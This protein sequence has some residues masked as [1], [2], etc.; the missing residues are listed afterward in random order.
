[1]N[2]PHTELTREYYF[3]KFNRMM[4]E[5]NYIAQEGEQIVQCREPHPAYWFI[6]NKGRLF[7]VYGNSLRVVTPNF[8]RSGKKNKN[9][10]RNGRQWR[11]GTHYNRTAGE[12]NQKY[13]MSRLIAEY[14][15]QNIFNSDE[16]M[17]VHHI[18]KRSNFSKDEASACNNIDNLQTLP[19]S[20][21]KQL[22]YFAGRTQEEL[23]ADVQRK[24][25][26]AKAPTFFVTQEQLL[27]LLEEALKQSLERGEQPVMYLTSLSNDI[28]QIEAEAKPIKDYRIEVI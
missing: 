8:D 17:E 14:F 4:E 20:V 5:M 11:Y 22:T 16:P 21:H 12:P 24:V 25:E 28:S 3:N 10:E 6:S 15:P 13:E 27:S 9:G 2:L 23:E 26:A 7:S 19:Q 18:R 1:M